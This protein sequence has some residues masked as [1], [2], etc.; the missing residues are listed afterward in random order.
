MTSY[1]SLG[2]GLGE[3]IDILR[4]ADPDVILTH[5]P[6]DYHPDHRYVGQLVFDA[7]HQKGLPNIPGPKRP[8]CRGWISNG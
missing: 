8:P 6:G 7:Y 1:P 2:F 4:E 3:S 5:S